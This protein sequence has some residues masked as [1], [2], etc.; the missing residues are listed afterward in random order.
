MSSSAEQR[1]YKPGEIVD[2]PGIYRVIHQQHRLPH[3]VTLLL[4]DVFPRCRTCGQ[5]VR[6][7]CLLS[8]DG[9]AILKH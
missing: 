7:E 8:A 9:I 3:E 4:N 2:R 5:A 6:F 1:K